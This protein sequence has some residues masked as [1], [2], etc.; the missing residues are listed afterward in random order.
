MKKILLYLFILS[1]IVWIAPSSYADYQGTIGTRFTIG[2]ES[3][4][5]FKSKVYLLN[6]TKKA[7]AKVEYWSDTS[8]TC[9]WTTKISP[10]TYPIFVQ[11]K[12][13]GVPPISAGNFTIMQPIIDEITPNNGIA[14]D[15]ITIN[16]WYFTNKKPKVYFEDPNTNK[17]KSCKVISFSMDPQ[18]G[19]STLQL[20]IPKWG[21]ENYNL[22]LITTIGQATVKF[23]FQGNKTSI[24]GTVAPPVGINPSSLTI[25]ALGNE[26]T[27]STGGN[28]AAGVYNEGVT[29]VSA[30]LE[31]KEFGLLNVIAAFAPSSSSSK[32]TEKKIKIAAAFKSETSDSI[33]LNAK[34]TAVSMVF[35][36][37][38]FFTND[39]QKAANLIQIIQNDSKVNDLANIIISVFNDANPLENPLLQQ[40]LNDAI[41]SVLTTIQNKA[42]TTNSF[43]KSTDQLNSVIFLP[44]K[45]HD[46]SLSA[47]AAEETQYS[48]DLNQIKLNISLQSNTYRVDVDSK[49]GSGVDWLGEI[50]A[51][52]S[53]QF[54]SINELQ[55]KA[56]NKNNIYERE[57]TLGRER[58]SAK[59]AL[60][61]LDIFGTLTDVA[62]DAVT[63]FLSLDG[64]Y[65]P[66]DVSK[67]YIL[68]S[69][70]G[71]GWQADSA[72]RNMIGNLPNGSFDDKKALVSNIVSAAIDLSSVIIDVNELSP[73]QDTKACYV[74]SVQNRIDATTGQSLSVTTTTD[75]LLLVPKITHEFTLDLVNCMI[76]E[77][78]KNLLKF[79]GNLI[80]KSAEDVAEIA[81]GYELLKIG[82]DLGMIMDRGNQL[83]FYATPVESA[84]IVVGNPFPAT[85]STYS[86]SGQVTYNGSGL[87]GVTVSLTGAASNSKTTD[88]NGNYTFDGLQNGLYT[89]TPSKTGYSFTPASPQ[90]TINN[91]NATQNFT[92]SLIP[93]STYSITGQVTYNG[94]GLSGVTITLTGAGSTST[95]TN[96]NGNYTFAGA[97]NGSYTVTPSMTGYT[98]TPASKAV[99]V[100]GANITG[101]NFSG[102]VASAALVDNGDGTVTDI[103]SGLMW[104]KAT[105]PGT[106][107]WQQ[108]LSYCES[109]SLAGHT[110]WRLPND[111]ELYSLVDNSR[112]WPDPTIDP[113]LAPYTHT[114]YYYWSS[115]TDYLHTLLAVFVDFFFG[116][117]GE[118]NK[119]ASLYVR[120]VRGGQST[121]Q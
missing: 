57:S 7:Y 31:N 107:T 71:G 15:T 112:S 48:I 30:M 87:S 63:D 75:W 69:F 108:A 62:F 11:P 36:T 3:F 37:P 42:Q 16:G 5:D 74:E 19:S 86:I 80:L 49:E 73:G 12:G 28:F 70:S 104:Q 4:G 90:V 101:T 99:T 9:L 14:G 13:K 32:L 59:S 79:V 17:R 2:G 8:I 89:I 92:A 98:F 33:E 45:S 113:L 6:G 56:N 97:Q 21:L 81:S 68:R 76:K 51:L 34:T 84:F 26:S 43:N 116:E 120:A 85:P 54:S 83:I 61:W 118:I 25:V 58:V 38:Y 106:Y 67:V 29:I 94:S 109:L 50:G 117:I 95:I 35:I 39:P 65:L 78:S 115:T 82:A 1:S 111:N 41:K 46:L 66:S 44:E 27:I 53:N 47:M 91:A 23:P 103:G 55:E 52:N 18:T 60:R 64:I 102:S 72:E 105:A 93:P 114:D 96:L 10:G 22:I 110:D 121:P 20:V 119:S 40:G 24:S 77:A 88:V 100:N